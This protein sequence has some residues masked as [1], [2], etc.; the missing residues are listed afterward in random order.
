MSAKKPWSAL[1][2]RVHRALKAHS[3]LLL[4]VLSDLREALGLELHVLHAHHGPTDEPAQAEFREAARALVEQKARA[5]GLPFSLRISKTPLTSE[6]EFRD[7]RREFFREVSAQE[8][9]AVVFLGHHAQDLLETRL[10]RLIRGTGSQGWDAMS[11]SDHP[12]LPCSREELAEEANARA[13]DFVEDP[14]NGDSRYLRNWLRQEWLPQLEAKSPGALRSFARS[15][16]N[17]V[18]VERSRDEQFPPE[19]LFSTAQSLHR[20]FYL[21]L[22]ASEQR[23]A[24]AYLI[25]SLKGADYSRG[26]I[27][28]I[29]KRLDNSQNEYTFNVAGLAFAVKSQEIRVSLEG[30]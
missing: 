21:R 14:S 4:E 26:Q 10:L 18:E 20:A 1:V 19:G 15:M 29:Q 17:W 16:E 22:S 12:F 24:W 13:L 5:L 27:E 8:G 3:M 23:R 7:F 9:L 2:H 6:E 25:H 11:E 30:K 28:E